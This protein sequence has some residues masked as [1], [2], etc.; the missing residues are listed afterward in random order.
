MPASQISQPPPA[1]PSPDSGKPALPLRSGKAVVRAV[2]GDIKFATS[3]AFQPL[4]SNMELLAGSIIKTGD[5]SDVY[6]QVNG[7]TSTVKI[8]SNSMV[9]LTKMEQQGGFIG[10]DSR[11]LLTLKVGTILASVRKLSAGSYYEIRTPNGVAAIR[12]TDFAIIAEP[13]LDGKSRVT[14]IAVTGQIIVSALVNGKEVTEALQ[15][16]QGWVPGEGKMEYRSDS[17]L[18]QRFFK[19]F[20]VVVSDSPPPPPPPDFIKPFNGNGPPNPAVNSGHN[21]VIIHNGPHPRG[22]GSPPPPAPVHR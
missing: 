3:G 12:G 2:Q 1:A 13:I 5:K 18:M 4:K 16:R 19:G 9:V 11:T 8:E 17:P 6:L 10:G 7:F 21:P 14:F 20:C 15:S 22:G